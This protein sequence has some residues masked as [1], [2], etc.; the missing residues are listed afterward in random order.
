MPP[1]EANHFRHSGGLI[2][3]AEDNDILRGITKEFLEDLGYRVITARD[4]TEA[5]EQHSY[6]TDNIVLAIFDV[7]MPRLSGP[8]AAKQICTIT[9][10]LPFLFVTGCDRKDLLE[11]TDIPQGFRVLR[12][13]INFDN[14]ND[15]IREIIGSN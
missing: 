14:F 6:H 15:T 1:A 13:P 9:P 4:G 3:L 12:K 7:M 5:V 10:S 8:E 2:L 11:K